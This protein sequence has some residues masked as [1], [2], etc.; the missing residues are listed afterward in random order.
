MAWDS[1][2]VPASIRWLILVLSMSIVLEANAIAIVLSVITSH[3]IP[4]P[5]LS[6]PP[7]SLLFLLPSK[8]ERSGLIRKKP[9]R[10]FSLIRGLLIIRSNCCLVY[11]VSLYY[12]LIT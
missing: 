12:P 11:L 3:R 1:S 8:S 9:G 4:T 6:F 5:T 2:S 7:P 10:Q